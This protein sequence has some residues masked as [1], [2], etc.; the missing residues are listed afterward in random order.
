MTLY[1]LSQVGE[2]CEITFLCFAKLEWFWKTEKV[3]LRECAL[4]YIDYI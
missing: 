3:V 1:L 4:K 2:V